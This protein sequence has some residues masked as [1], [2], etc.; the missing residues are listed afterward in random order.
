MTLSNL[1]VRRLVRAGLLLVFLAALPGVPAAATVLADLSP[2]VL[3]KID[4]RVLAQTANGGQAEFLVVLADQADLSGAAALPTK[5]EK[6]RYVFHTLLAM[7]HS[8]Q[9]PLLAWLQ[10]QH[11]EYRSYAIVNMLWVKGDARLAQALAARADVAKLEA[12]PLVHGAQAAPRLSN[13]PAGAPAPAGIEPNVTYIHADQLWTLGFKG[14]GIVIGSGDTGVQWDHPAL[15]PHYRGWNGSSADHNDNWHDS[16]HDSSSGSCGFDSP[17]PCDDFG[18]GTHTTGTAIGD[19]GSGNQ[20]GVAP[21]AQ[22]IGCRNMDQGIGTPA[23]YIECFEFFLAPYPLTGTVADGTPDLAPDVTTNSWTCPISE[24]CSADIPN[25]LRAAIQAQQ[26][27]GIL[28]VVAAGNDGPDCSSVA[29]PP[30]IYGEAYTVGAL[31]TGSDSIAFFSGRGPVTF[32]GSSRRKP[33]ISAP[34]T[35]VRSSVRG[36]GYGNLS[37]T[38][39]ATPAVAG[40]V[41]L[42]WSALPAL[43]GQMSMTEQIL[44]DSAVPLDSTVCGSTGWPNNTFG[45][46]RLDV[47]AAYDLA[48]LLAGAVTGTV[49]SSLGGQIS[50]AKVRLDENLLNY[51]ATTSPAGL[52][53]LSLLSGTYTVTASA[54]GYLPFSVGGMSLPAGITTT[55]PL[56]LTPAINYFLPFVAN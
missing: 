27:A 44:N 31:Q 35:N 51:V 28:T 52:Y 2:S 48:G 20:I 23:R 37:G 13:S 25:V 3:S 32:D 29:E 53:N 21:G 12:N 9:A 43:R 56:T 19:D 30:S 14:Q 18:H 15:K 17:A 49:S 10:A 1:L 4:P 42:L 46:G 8:T 38:S 5:L 33:D 39:M 34:G 50:G 22:W 26:A 7:A 11:A 6:G 16:I 24:G 41:A 47:K 54:F 40:A 36:N 55:L 45:Y